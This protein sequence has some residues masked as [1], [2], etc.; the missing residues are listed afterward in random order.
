MNVLKVDCDP[1]VADW[2]SQRY[3]NLQQGSAESDLPISGYSGDVD[4]IIVGHSCPNPVSLAK[5][6]SNWPSAP[7]TVFLSTREALDSLEE[8][9]QYSPG[10]G[11][12]IAVCEFEESAFLIQLDHAIETGRMR[13]KLGIASHDKHAAINSNVSPSWLLQLLL[14]YL[15]EYIYFKDREGRFLAISDY[16]AIRCGLDNPNQAIG[17]T[18][19]DLFDNEHA[20]EAAADE[21]DLVAGKIDRVEKEEY[22]T[23]EGNKIWVQS[24]KLPMKSRSGY[25]MGSFGISRDITAKKLMAEQIERQ[26]KQF[27]DELKLARTLQESLLTKGTSQFKTP[28]GIDQLNFDARHIASSQLSGDFYSVLRTSKGNAAIFLADVMGHGAQAAMVTAMLYAAVNE[29][30]HHAHEPARFMQ[31]INMKL[32]SWLSEKGHVFF[33]TGILCYFDFDKQTCRICQNGGS[34]LLLSSQASPDIPVNPAL[35]LI[36]QGTFTC[37]ELEYRSNDRFLFFTDGIL[38][39][40]NETGEIFGIDRLKDTFQQ[41]VSAND[42]EILD[43]IIAQLQAFT[44]KTAEEDDI[45]LLSTHMLTSPA[46]ALANGSEKGTE[47]D[48]S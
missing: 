2:L 7:P 4:I 8:R 36:P 12:N 23:W 32:Y 34:H 30:A 27:E 45:C 26:H 43:T 47:A 18:D 22:V 44:R 20:D 16:L 25:T 40:Q 39:A 35:G 6:I 33:A 24:L 19:F 14:K 3:P 48:H 41:L 29:I 37:K 1:Q 21:A 28:D 9:M 15:P 17:L 11:K 38:E 13:Q 10:V 31:E 42:N 46:S 5:A